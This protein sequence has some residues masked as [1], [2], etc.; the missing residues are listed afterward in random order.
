[1][2]N[3]NPQDEICELLKQLKAQRKVS[4]ILLQKLKEAERLIGLQAM[5]LFKMITSNSSS[6]SE[7]E[8]QETNQENRSFTSRGPVIHTMSEPDTD[9]EVDICT[10]GQ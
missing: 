7:D 10:C 3:K 8:T 5:Q 9:E 4:S 2:S 6:S 1:M